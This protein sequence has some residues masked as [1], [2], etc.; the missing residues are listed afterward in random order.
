[1][2]FALT[3]LGASGSHTGPGRLCSGYLLRTEATTILVD[4]GNG[5]TANLQR[6]VGLGDLDAVVV[7]H[8]HVDHCVDL[9]GCFYAL[10]FDPGYLGRLALY[11][12][13]EVHAALTSLL[14]SDTALEFD[15]VFDHTEIRGGDR[16]DIGDMHFEVFDSVH[17]V[18][19]VSMRVEVDG[20]VFAFSG[21]SAGGE[22]LVACARDADVFLC[23]ATWQGDATD[24]PDGIHL[25][26][27]QA[28]EVATTAG[29]R[30]LVLTHIAGGLDRS[31]SQHEASE[32]FDGPVEVA[33]EMHDYQIR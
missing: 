14:S 25:T 28:G 3:V 24:Y 33:E 9:I 17:S 7:S 27:R 23:E 8:R 29:A 21:D 10:R 22:Q 2:G 12:G 15:E 16:I 18:P 30:R 19:A 13:P 32:T 26:A 31:V 4:A 6:L 20:S 11:A 1:M 5:S